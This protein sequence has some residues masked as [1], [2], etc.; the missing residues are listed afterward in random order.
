MKIGDLV[1][2]RSDWLKKS[3]KEDP[4]EWDG[5]S[6]G[7]ILEIHENQ[8]KPPDY[9]TEDAVLVLWTDGHDWSWRSELEKVNEN[10]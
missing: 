10:R 7:I 3:R 5:K 1:R 4:E 2:H 6:V 8:D 9:R